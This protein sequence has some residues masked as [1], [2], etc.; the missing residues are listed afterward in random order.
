MPRVRQIEENLRQAGVDPRV[1]STI[2]LLAERQRI[3]HQQ[4]ASCAEVIGKLMDMLQN[5]LDMLGVRDK[6]LKQLG[7]E[8]MIKNLD[9]RRADRGVKVESVE[10]FDADTIPANEWE[11][12]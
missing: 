11:K 12:R 10:E 1:I 9:E 3:Q 5:V 6:R 8:E 2:C 4:L 7:I